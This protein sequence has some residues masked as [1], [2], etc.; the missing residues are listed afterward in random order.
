MEVMLIMKCPVCGSRLPDD[1]TF[2]IK[3]GQ[4]VTRATDQGS[5]SNSSPQYTSNA[6]STP[7]TVPPTQA[8]PVHQAGTAK[9]KA[10]ILIAVLGTILA[11][12]LCIFTFFII[13]PAFEMSASKK[14]ATERIADSGIIDTYEGTPDGNYSV[15][16]TTSTGAAVVEIADHAY[17]ISHGEITQIDFPDSLEI[18]GEDAFYGQKLTELTLPETVKTL[19]SGAFG[20]N[21]LKEVTLNEGLEYIGD[22]SFSHNDLKEV[23]IPSTVTYIGTMAFALNY[24]MQNVTFMEGTEPATIGSNAF[25]NID[26]NA[27]AQIVIPGNYVNI[28]SGN[29]KNA[30][31]VT[32]LPS[33]DGS[34]QVYGA[35]LGITEFHGGDTITE[36]KD[37]G[38]FSHT[39]IF[40]PK[41]SY[42]EKFAED[43]GLEFVVEPEEGNA[44]ALSELPNAEYNFTKVEGD[45]EA[46]SELQDAESVQQFVG[47]YL[48]FNDGDEKGIISDAN[49]NAIAI[50]EAERPYT[51]IVD[52]PI[53]RFDQTDQFNA[54]EERDGLEFSVG[55][56]DIGKIIYVY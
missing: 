15:P 44:D 38:F 40:G 20:S 14:A 54:A 13:I 17:D 21:D 10:I 51:G 23:T 12:A 43:N 47:Y 35:A 11:G 19:K 25:D 53:I 55:Y 7:Y 1:A 6:P 46:L 9:N 4:V 22:N 41:G 24:S 26:S 2:C 31:S 39:T 33:P 16:S 56:D 32:L 42:L 29:F 27:K 5:S 36:I 48:T 49:G 3:C 18:I 37:A 28:G 52:V 34:P 8:Y 50:Y 30:Y 45:T